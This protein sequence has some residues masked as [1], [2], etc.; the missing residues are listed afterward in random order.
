MKE[1]EFYYSIGATMYMLIGFLFN[2][3]Y[4]GQN[5]IACLLLVITCIILY[6]LNK[7]MVLGDDTV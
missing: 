2:Y 3:F 7:W 1:K 4:I 6:F 5:H